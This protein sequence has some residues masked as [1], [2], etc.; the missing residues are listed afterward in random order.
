MAPNLY[1][2]L[3]D[4]CSYKGTGGDTSTIGGALGSGWLA[5]GA[6]TKQRRRRRAKHPL[7]ALYCSYCSGCVGVLCKEGRLCPAYRDSSHRTDSF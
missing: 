6:A 7:L 5:E 3:R 4:P 1:Y 2:P